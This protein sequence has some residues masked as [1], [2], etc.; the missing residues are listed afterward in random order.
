MSASAFMR[1]SLRHSACLMVWARSPTSATTLWGK[2]SPALNSLRFG[3]AG[4]E[5]F[6]APIRA[7]VPALI[8]LGRLLQITERIFRDEETDQDL[9]LIFAPGSIR[10]VCRRRTSTST[11][12]PARLTCLRRPWCSSAS[13][14]C[15]ARAIIK[16]VASV[17]AMWRETAKATGARSAEITR[18]A[19]AFEHDD[20]RRR[21][22]YDLYRTAAYKRTIPEG[23]DHSHSM[24]PGGFDVTS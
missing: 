6:Q 15:G 10:R 20:L 18:M 11:R 23:E 1:A 5:G 13:H 21:W 7:G 19:S 14:C 4:E 12:A 2:R 24:V 3:W 8:E 16:E 22:R 17:T 9:Q